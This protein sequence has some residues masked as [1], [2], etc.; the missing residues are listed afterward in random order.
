[1]GIYASYYAIND[2]QANE[3]KALLAKNGEDSTEQFFESLEELDDNEE[4]LEEN[5]ADLDKLWDS[6]HY[7]LTGFDSDDD[8]NANKT[9]EQLALYYGFFGTEELSDEGVYLLT[10][11]KITNV[12][13][14]LE[15]VNID[16]LLEK[17]DFDKFRKADL[18]PDIWYN[19]DKDDLAD[20]LKEYFESF[21]QFYQTALKNNRSVLITIC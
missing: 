8:H 13:R 9:P 5:Y 12:V 16:E 21:K 1:M 6:L 4:F 11:D 7:L 14:A 17:V 18:Y 20:E 3:Y 10:A 19:E 2:N 15:S